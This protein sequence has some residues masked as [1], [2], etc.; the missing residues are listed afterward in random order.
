MIPVAPAS[1]GLPVGAGQEGP[2]PAICATRRRAVDLPLWEPHTYGGSWG[3]LVR[4]IQI[5]VLAVICVSVSCCTRS[6]SGVFTGPVTG[7]VVGGDCVATGP[8]FFNEHG[9]ASEVTCFV[10][11][12]GKVGSCVRVVAHTPAANRQP[13]YRFPVDS[14]S[15]VA[16]RSFE[17]SLASSAGGQPTPLTAAEHLRVSGF[18]LPQS[19]WAVA[20]TDSS[21]SWLVSGS[22]FVHAVQGSDGSWQVDRGMHCG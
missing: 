19:G 2:V 22:T 20:S 15:P 14:S 16:S 4:V 5:V 21:G 17:L 11:M 7:V 18:S 3:V 9:Q 6:T 8:T 12:V 10:H 13:P 1:R